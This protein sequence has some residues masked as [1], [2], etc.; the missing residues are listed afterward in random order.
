MKRNPDAS[1]IGVSELARCS[2][3]SP[4]AMSR[5]LK[6]IEE[7]GLAERMIDSKNRRKTYVRL[8][9]A[10]EQARQYAWE[11]STE[12]INRVMEEMGE[13]KMDAFLALWKELVDIMEK[14]IGMV[15]ENPS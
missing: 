2:F 15:S 11:V 12:Y 1:G 6:S 3:M 4:P 7:K 10:G 13:E 8:T 5:T 9:Q 14:N